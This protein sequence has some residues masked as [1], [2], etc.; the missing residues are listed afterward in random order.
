MPEPQL[1]PRLDASG[2][3][4]ENPNPYRGFHD[5]DPV[6]ILDAYPNMPPFSYLP[7]FMRVPNQLPY[8]SLP[9][10]TTARGGKEVGGLVHDY[11]S[12]EGLWN[13]NPSSFTTED[14]MTIEEREIADEIKRNILNQFTG[15]FADFRGMNAS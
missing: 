5:Y 11:L 7:D 10:T 8:S 9:F 6:S 4:I 14:F 13:T 12:G 2:N 3:L 15:G 1:I